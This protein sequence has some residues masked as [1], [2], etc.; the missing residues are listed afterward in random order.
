MSAETTV[1]SHRTKDDEGLRVLFCLGVLPEFFSAGGETQAAL[2]SGIPAAFEDLGGRFGLT[3][4]GTMDDDELMVGPSHAWP[5]TA[6]I[7]ADAP[8]LDAVIA[9]CDL[10][11]STRIGDDRLWRFMRIEAR[12][13]RRLFFGNA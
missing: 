7:L 13:G 1:P 12:V 2:L 11:R 9:V 5:W 3:V 8:D 6:Y 4:L 10:V